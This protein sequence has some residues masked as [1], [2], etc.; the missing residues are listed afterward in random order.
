[1]IGRSAVKPQALPERL[2]DYRRSVLKQEFIP[3]ASFLQLVC[4]LDQGK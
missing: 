2:P 3:Q 1:M 4:R